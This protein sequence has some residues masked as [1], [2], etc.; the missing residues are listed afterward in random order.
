M[1]QDLALQYTTEKRSRET[2]PNVIQGRASDPAANVWV[3]ASAGTGKTKVLTDRVLRLLLPRENTEAG[4]EPHRILCLT[5]TKAAASEMA[6]RINEKLSEW[7]VMDDEEL[8]ETLSKLMQRR[9][10]E[11]DLAAARRLFAAVVDTPGGLKIMTIH[12]FC[13]SVLSRFPLE[14][15]ISPHFS[16]MDDS[17]AHELLDQASE[18]VLLAARKGDDPKIADA[19]QRLSALLN[20]QDF[21]QL[22]KQICSEP[23]QLEQMEHTEENYQKLIW[24]IL[25]LKP[26]QSRANILEQIC[27]SADEESLWSACKALATGSKTDAAR[28]IA[29]QNWLEADI[30]MRI[31]NLDDYMSAYLTSSGGI[32][33]SLITK[34]CASTYPGAEDALFKEAE[35]IINSLDLL[36]SVDTAQQSSDALMIGLAIMK[37]Y[38]AEKSAQGLMDYNDLIVKT[39][40]LLKTSGISPWVLYKLDGGIDHVLID[41]AQD[42]NPE[43]WDIIEALCDDFFAGESRDTPDDRTIFTVGDEKQSIYSFQ[44]AAPKEFD[45]MRRTFE[46]RTTQAK[47]LWRDESMNTS[48]RSTPSVLDIVD[49]VFQDEETKKGLGIDP[50]AHHSHHSGRAGSVTLWPLF[51]LA[52]QDQKEAP[53]SPPIAR[54]EVTSPQNMMAEHIGK[55]IRSWL[56]EG[57]VLESQNRTIQAGDIM[58]L[59]RTRTAFVAQLVRALKTRNIPV[60]GVDRMIL[61]KELVVWDLLSL[62]QFA[63]LPEDDLTLACILKSPFIGFT[64]EELEDLCYQRPGTLWSQLKTHPAMAKKQDIVA[65]LKGLINMAGSSQPYEFFSQILH[66][67]CPQDA[68]NAKRAIMKRLGED[69]LDPLEEFLNSC[70]NFETSKISDLQ[71]FLVWMEQEDLVIKREMEEAGGHVRIMTVHG[72]KGL[73]A[74]IVFLPDTTRTSSSKRTDRLLWPDKTNMPV[75]LWTANKDAECQL[76]K[77]A[78][79]TLDAYM[80]EEYRRLLYVALTRAEDHLYIGG[81]QGKRSPIDDSWYRYVEKGFL[82]MDHVAKNAFDGFDAYHKDS[83]TDQDNE[84]TSLS[85]HNPQTDQLKEKDKEDRLQHDLEYQ[86]PLPA[87]VFQTAPE[88]PT[89]P[90]PLCPSR[91]SE[92]DQEP[93]AQSP[94][95]ADDNYR[96]RRGN[97]THS[98][99]QFL[100]DLPEDQQEHAAKLYVEKH[101]QDLNDKIRGEIVQE[102]MRILMHPDYGLIFGPNSQAEVPLTGLIGEKMMNGQIDRLLIRDDEKDI[103]VIDYK[104]NRPPPKTEDK[105]PEI[106]ISQMKSYRDALQIIYPDYKIHSLLLW[107]D[108][109][110]VT[111][112]KNL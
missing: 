17:E 90:R 3:G 31:E 73:Q 23:L 85:I 14:A 25:G 13:Q 84:A 74:P 47:K 77:D 107:T 18:T 16:V 105:V 28:G 1:T 49:A 95:I 109:P 92:L 110:F 79:S 42:T 46:S 22:I 37:T 45:R 68:T 15:K 9:P 89:P 6:L 62:A 5:F 39:R 52:E 70:L 65:W 111:Y 83:G 64:D 27:S 98:L 41:E 48:F 63:V 86:T 80:D 10:T 60:S 101:A 87:W 36:K 26:D 32:R 8:S 94:L 55:T 88:E 43:Q 71:E 33:K 100:P 21:T 102:T 97:L 57:Q 30:K 99:L 104:T 53:W 93:A 7:V 72:A 82:S 40:E 96:F 103:W 34:P 106:Y 58:I 108:G 11:S 67:P 75:P 76:Y 56:D 69:A 61:G 51:K 38:R 24:E 29:I 54:Q 91:P 81:W 44:R 66:R 78:R 2:D 19:I 20:D 12:S 112:L 35:R 50:V 59:V 4:T